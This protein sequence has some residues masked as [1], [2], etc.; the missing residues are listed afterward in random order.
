MYRDV[1]G[2]KNKKPLPKWERIP[3]DGIDEWK[4]NHADLDTMLSSVQLFESEKKLDQDKHL[5][6]L[7]FDLDKDG[8]VDL[9]LSDARTLVNHF[10]SNYEIEP[11]IWFSGCKGFHIQIDYRNFG[12]IDP[13]S[14]LTYIWKYLAIYISDQ[15]NLQTVDTTV[16]TI[17]R[18]WRLP[19][20]YHYKSGLY[21]IPLSSYE[22]VNLNIDQIKELA[23]EPR[24]FDSTDV[25][26]EIN[27]ALQTLY[28]QA[29]DTYKK[30]SALDMT[31]VTTN[32]IEFNDAI[33]PCIK[34]L[35]SNGGVIKMGYRNR[36]SMVIAGY[37]KDS[38]MSIDK[39]QSF[40]TD[41]VSL[42]SKDSR[43]T[44]E[45]NPNARLTGALIVLK[46]VYSSDKYHF[47][48]GS[49]L[50]C[51]IPRDL[52]NE[53]KSIG[54]IP[55]E[56]DLFSY[57]MAEN[58]GK[59]IVVDGDVIGKDRK[60]L[61]IPK[62]VTGSCLF[63]PEKNACLTCEMSKYFDIDRKKNERVM[64]FTSKNKSI[65]DLVDQGAGHIHSVLM[66]LFGV[67][68]KNC[69]IFNLDIEYD[70]AQIIHI[71][72]RLNYDFR[73]EDKPKRDTA[74]LLQHGIELNRSYKLFGRIYQN[75]RTRAATFIIDKTEP[76]T[77]MLDNFNIT[78][79]RK[80]E[81][82]IFQASG[83]M[84][85]QIMN[86]IQEMHSSFRDNFIYVFGRD[87]LIL[88]VDMVFHSARWINFQ[89]Q[90]IKGWLDILILGDTRQGK[91][92]VVKKL[93]QYYKLG[94]MAAGET[95]SRTGLIYTIQSIK[96]EEA[97]VSFGLLPR[98]NGYLVV[99]DEI[100]GMP[101]EDFK[102]FTLVRSEGVVD[103]KRSAYGIAKA[104]TRL[105]SIANARAGM[106]LASYG[107]PVQAITEIPAFTS[108][109]DVSRFDYCVGVR[110]GDV[111]D[112]DIN[113]DV[114]LLNVSSSIYTPDL[115][116]DLI[117]WI[118]TLKPE[119]I[120]IDDETQAYTLEVS[121]QMSMEYVPDIPLVESADI[122]HKIIRLATAIAGRTYNS[123]DGKHLIVNREHIICAYDILSNL[124]K[125]VG[126]DYWGF[127]EDKARLILSEDAAK[128]LVNRFQGQILN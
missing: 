117:L 6:D 9:A 110:A 8:N 121:K 36:T 112:D 17:P 100:H 125:S 56:L 91:T 101:A 65:I 53:C 67:S 98:C 105:I 38:G 37:C 74:I 29:E 25:S 61:L 103:V 113:T 76:L 126:L 32:E 46:K 120:I 42:I 4:N 27:P 83:D 111:S 116:R 79:Q 90:R 115:C 102:Q 39:A 96:G 104:E 66:K 78:D 73:T 72:S 3:E 35:L 106:S 109:E 87:E 118:W 7:Y 70:N 99:V 21:K 77:T 95:C 93:M 14:K 24:G 47:S 128:D 94:T 16:Y 57:T 54:E 86:K 71:A 62:R 82:K 114:N 13:L 59:F 34:Y 108:L 69:P 45:S 22:L 28:H 60:E 64:V 19:N 15:L 107:Y 68:A 80:D 88:A 50:D 75:P 30:S 2:F 127:S 12:V 119:D 52:C 58:I 18:M 63:D 23:K 40:I 89:K 48:C 122:R 41:W 92:E 124:Y 84:A 55:I 123:P 5:V 10:L 26:D 43:L 44:S 85:D 1:H 33:P 11:K 97:W 51:G 49:M 20:T 81:L 31:L